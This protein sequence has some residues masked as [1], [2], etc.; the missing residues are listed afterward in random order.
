MT[1]AAWHDGDA[2]VADTCPEHVEPVRWWRLVRRLADVRD[3]HPGR[4]ARWVREQ[5]ER[6][7]AGR[8]RRPT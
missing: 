6:L 3:E 2:W 4:T 8:G 1:V 5:L 7:Y